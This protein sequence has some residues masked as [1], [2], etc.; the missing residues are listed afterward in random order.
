MQLLFGVEAEFPAQCRLILEISVELRSQKVH[1][2]GTGHGGV[3]GLHAVGL[4]AG[5]CARAPAGLHTA[6]GIAVHIEP[7][8]LLLRVGEHLLPVEVDDLVAAPDVVVHMA[9]DGLVV[10]HAAGHQH[11][12][13]VL[14]EEPQP[15]G[16]K[17]LADLGSIAAPLQLQLEQKVALILADGVFI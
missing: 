4:Q 15:L 5:G 7:V 2:D 11:L 16:V 17:Q 13:L 12:R 8:A 3:F 1:H 6:L 14:A 9:V 10:V